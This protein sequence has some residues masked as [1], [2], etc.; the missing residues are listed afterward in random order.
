MNNLNFILIT[1][2]LLTG[3]TAN[4]QV[5]TEMHYQEPQDSSYY[6]DDYDHGIHQCHMMSGMMHHNMKGHMGMMHG[7]HRYGMMAVHFGNEMHYGMLTRLREIEE[8]LGLSS[9]Q[10]S[11]LEE[12]KEEFVQ[13]REKL[14][15]NVSNEREKL[16]E[17]IN[18]KV[19]SEKYRDQLMNYYH[20]L[21]EIQES[22]YGHYK[23][24]RGVLNQEQ[25]QE[26]KNE[27]ADICPYYDENPEN[28]EETDEHHRKGIHHNM[29]HD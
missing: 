19:S 5:H 7:M 2:F 26:L 20:S 10:I 11:R 24:M 29:M 15:R 12:I 1:V 8:H 6:I 13:R 17:H 14:Y 23:K 16:M 25:K 9:G 3:M 18:N 4:S 28:H 22:A 27:I 21:I